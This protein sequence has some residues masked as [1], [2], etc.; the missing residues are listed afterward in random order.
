MGILK[1]HKILDKFF[2]IIVLTVVTFL[3]ISGSRIQIEDKLVGTW[4]ATD[5]WNN[6]SEFVVTDD[7]L[8]T[9][10]INNQRFGGDD[11]QINGKPVELKY[12]INKANTPIWFDLVA[13][14]KESGT[15][16]LKVKGLIEFINYNKAKIL[17]NL[18]N[19]RITNFDKKYSKKIITIER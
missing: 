13:T 3:C 10:S 15:P 11:F 2:K 17:L 4:K 1:N 12:L 14:D 16:L 18:D 5:Y 6:T 19:R 8:V 7:K 9:L